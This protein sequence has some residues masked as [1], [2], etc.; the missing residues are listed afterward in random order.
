MLALFLPKSPP[1][2]CAKSSNWSSQGFV[3]IITRLLK[4]TEVHSVQKERI[5]RSS[6]TAIIDL[7]T[8]WLWTSS[9]SFSLTQIRHCKSMMRCSP[10]TS[11][12]QWKAQASTVGLCRSEQ[13][14]MAPAYNVRPGFS[15]ILLR[16]TRVERKFEI[17]TYPFDIK[18]I[19]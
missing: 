4:E 9:N 5:Q 15:V 19:Y 13:N 17:D 16:G 1:F 2:L 14:L 18:E 10:L 6:P 12:G 7:T 8:N 3:G 11:V